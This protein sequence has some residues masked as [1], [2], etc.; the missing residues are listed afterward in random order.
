MFTLATTATTTPQT[1]QTQ[2]SKPLQLN[3]LR[4][5]IKTYAPFTCDFFFALVHSSMNE[6]VSS[7]FHCISLSLYFTVSFYLFVSLSRTLLL[8][9]SRFRPHCVYISISCYSVSSFIAFTLIFRKPC[10]LRCVL[11][12]VHTLY[13]VVYR[14]IDDHSPTHGILLQRINV[15]GK[16]LEN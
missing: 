12:A 9:F 6:V 14:Q 1:I 11:A 8:L 3:K 16:M 7:L 4:A 13:I 2:R 5:A 15:Q 10:C